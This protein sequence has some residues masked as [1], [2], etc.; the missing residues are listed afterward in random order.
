[1]AT[2]AVQL[3]ISA[4]YGLTHRSTELQAGVGVSVF[5]N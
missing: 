1:M 3:D 2:H 4:D 5:F